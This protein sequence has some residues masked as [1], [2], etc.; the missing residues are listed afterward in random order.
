[1]G[2]NVRC[3]Y[4]QIS[5]LHTLLKSPSR[6]PIFTGGREKKP[7][8]VIELT[9]AVTEMA[10][11]N[12]T[13]RGSCSIDPVNAGGNVQPPI[14]AVGISPSKIANLRSNYL[15]QLRDLHSLL[16]SGAINDREFQEQKTPIL[17]QLR[18]FVP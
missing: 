3:R 10:K 5:N 17:E 13:P 16:E 11:A 12:D 15:Q 6:V 7:N 4:L 9:S 1:M 8:Q 18:K 14:A 2:R